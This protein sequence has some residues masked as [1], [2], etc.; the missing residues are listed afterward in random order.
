MVIK[1]TTKLAVVAAITGLVMWVVAGLWHNLVLPKLDAAHDAHHRGLG[2][3]LAAYV[4]LGGLMT[5]LYH[6]TRRGRDTRRPALGGAVFGGMIGVLWVF[7]HELALAGA[8]QSPL[9]DVVE[10][11]SWHAIEQGSGG[12]AMALLLAT[13]ALGVPGLEPRDDTT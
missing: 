2:I 7:P 12:I 11:A 9:L 4:I 13:R 5:G 3:M 8:H 10:N 1:H 6:R